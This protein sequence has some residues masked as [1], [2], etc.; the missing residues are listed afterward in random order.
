[1]AM[2]DDVLDGLVGPPDVW[3]EGALFA[4]SGIDGPTD[5]LSSFIARATS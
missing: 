1:M 4:L 2:L 3:V 5:L